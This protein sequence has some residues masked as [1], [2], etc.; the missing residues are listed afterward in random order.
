MIQRGQCHS[1]IVWG[2]ASF[3]YILYKC[4]WL[5]VSPKRTSIMWGSCES[6]GLR[7]FSVFHVWEC[8]STE[9]QNC[10]RW[11]TQFFHCRHPLLNITKLA[12]SHPP[13]QSFGFGPVQILLDDRHI[14]DTNSGAVPAKFALSF[15]FR[16][17]FWMPGALWFVILTHVTN[18][19]ARIS[20]T[21]DWLP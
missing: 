11:T 5:W 9:F 6:A 16:A 17:F 1:L 21:G 8:M 20:R 12:L 19:L 10:C 14:W 18:K 3:R 15:F 4:V 2:H 7:V 13:A